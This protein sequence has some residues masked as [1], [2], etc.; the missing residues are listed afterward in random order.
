MKNE[1]IKKKFD[2][3]MTLLTE[4]IVH[5][6]KFD[7]WVSDGVPTVDLNT[8]AKS[9]CILKNTDDGIFAYRR[10][11]RVDKV[12]SFDDLLDLVYGCTNGEYFSGRWI[13][14][15]RNHGF[16]SPIN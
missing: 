6:C 3:L 11:D 14:I 13:D 12:D 2:E 8:C 9:S 15:L 4:P 1:E 10:Y 5:G 16:D 7:I